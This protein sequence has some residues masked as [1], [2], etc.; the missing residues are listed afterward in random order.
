[1]DPTI[2]DPNAVPAGGADPTG[3]SVGGT[4]GGGVVG[5]GGA[6][7]AGGGSVAPPPAP[8]DLSHDGAMFNDAADQLSVQ[9]QDGGQFA[10]DINTMASDFQAVVATP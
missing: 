2:V 1:M 5:A 3:G 8:V 6:G 7:G 10:T 9:N 4:T